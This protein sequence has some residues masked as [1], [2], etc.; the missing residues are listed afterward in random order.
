M[1]SVYWLSQSRDTR[2]TLNVHKPLRRHPGD[3]RNNLS[4][5]NLRHASMS[6]VNLLNSNDN[7]SQ[8]EPYPILIL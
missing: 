8:R 7:L 3:L 2:R 4:I 1:Y 5:F 6:K